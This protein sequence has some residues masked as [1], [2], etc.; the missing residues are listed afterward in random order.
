MNQ[1]LDTMSNTSVLEQEPEG[2]QRVWLRMM[3]SNMR[4]PNQMRMRISI[5]ANLSAA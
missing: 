5:L 2:Y 4:S 3:R 1:T